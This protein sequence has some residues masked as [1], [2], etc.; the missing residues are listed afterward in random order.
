MLQTL[1]YCSVR[2]DYFTLHEEK[3]QRENMQH[4]ALPSTDVH[5]RFVYIVKRE[6]SHPKLFHCVIQ[7]CFFVIM[8][9]IQQF[10]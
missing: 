5:R 7:C 8:R 1:L 3:L 9:E 4:S 10:L 2:K 6:F